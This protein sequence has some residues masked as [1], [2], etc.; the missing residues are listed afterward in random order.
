MS[1]SFDPSIF[2]DAQLTEPLE[3]RAPLA[4]GDYTAIIKDLTSRAWTGKSDPSKSGIAL[5]VILTVE[6]PFELQEGLGGLTTLDM[7]DSIMLDLTPGGTIDNGVGKNRKL[8]NYREALDMN[9][10]GDAFSPRGM[11]GRPIKVKVTH[12]VWEGQPQER[13]GGVTRA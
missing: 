8:R 11:I 2:L 10:V 12:E 5:D 3:K 7:K 13:V 9:K 6:V 4:I 1:S